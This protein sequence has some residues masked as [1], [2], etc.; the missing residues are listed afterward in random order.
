ML[1]LHLLYFTKISYLWI[2]FLQLD[3]KL[4]NGKSHV[5]FIFVLIA[6]SRVVGAQQKFIKFLNFDKTYWITNLSYSWLSN[7]LNWSRN[8][9]VKI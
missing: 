8:Y 3:Y 4:F 1:L 6:L 5:L 9:T 7:A 2:F